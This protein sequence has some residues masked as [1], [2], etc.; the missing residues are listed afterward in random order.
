MTAAKFFSSRSTWLLSIALSM[1]GCS[2]DNKGDTG[3]NGNPDMGL[4]DTGADVDMGTVDLGQPD[5]GSSPG[6]WSLGEALTEGTAPPRRGDMA[7]AFDPATQRAI[8]F[9]GDSAEPENC[10]FAGSQFLN[11]GY[12]YDLANNRWYPLVVNGANVPTPRARSRGLWDPVRERFILFGGRWR[13]G[14]SGPYT[15]LN[16]VWAL[17][18]KTGEWTEL[19][20]FTTAQTAPSG[21]MNFG[22]NYDEAND[23]MIL[24][25]G[26]TTDFAQFFINSDTWVF[27]FETNE[28]SQIAQGNPQPVP[29]IFHAFAF[30]QQG[31]RLFVFSGG[32]EDAFTMTSFFGDMWMLDVASETW[33]EIT[34]T[35]PAGRIKGEMIYDG[36]RS[37]LLLFAGH[38]DSNLGNNNDIWSF[39][40]NALTWT[41]E[42]TGD[43]FNAPNI[44]F[45]DF[46]GNFAAVDIN[47]PERRESHL[48]LRA[49]ADVA[50]MYGG[51]TDCGLANDTWSL[52]LSSLSWTQLN[53][54]PTGMT[55][56]R[57]GNPNCDD[58]AARMCD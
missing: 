28:W 39:D 52:D 15:F 36:E 22:I 19:S 14:N 11:D 35:M 24:H 47:S 12:V 23:R 33:T 17:D 56:V 29:R 1:A 44:G 6:D 16:D 40:L 38:D 31:G 5:M 49:G 26:G 53:P 37:R 50:L 54:S 20:P 3:G 13:D 9:F 41:E 10:G 42:V 4:M 25:G 30:D 58:A 8:M 57:N 27:S 21:R 34:G 48:F 32:G 7:A 55:C 43:T 45:C 46:P 51:R 2:S 18:P